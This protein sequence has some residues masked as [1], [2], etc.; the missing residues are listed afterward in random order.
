M[1]ARARS[2]VP[3]LRANIVFDPD[4]TSPHRRLVQTPLPLLVPV[5]TGDSLP[6]YVPI[7]PEPIGQSRL[8]RS[9]VKI[10]DAPFI[11]ALGL[12]RYKPIYR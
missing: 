9:D 4:T 5:N 12:F 7:P 1:L 11:P 3:H 2:V 10:E 8:K 6:E